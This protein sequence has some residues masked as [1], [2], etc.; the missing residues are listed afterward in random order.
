[1]HSKILLFYVNFMI[2]LSSETLKSSLDQ[3]FSGNS[4]RSV[5]RSLNID[6]TALIRALVK[7][8]KQGY[9]QALK[10]KK[11]GVALVEEHI[12]RLRG[13]DKDRVKC[14][15]EDNKPKILS[16]ER[17]HPNLPELMSTQQEH[18]RTVRETRCPY[19]ERLGLKPLI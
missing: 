6:S 13:K 8:D 4:M 15:L 14:W 11:G 12:G 3:M 2:K 5:A 1:M 7:F 18:N 16:L 10:S 17:E 19:F 9:Y